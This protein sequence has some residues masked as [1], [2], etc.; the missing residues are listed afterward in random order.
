VQNT[1]AAI[2]LVVEGFRGRRFWYGYHKDSHTSVVGVRE[3]A[4][5]GCK[6]FLADRE[7]EAWIDQM[8]EDGDC[9]AG[10]GGVDEEEPLC[11]LFA[12]PGQSNMTGR[13]LPRDWYDLC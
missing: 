4:E 3:L 8:D 6:C 10:G 11:R 12:Y 1:T 13:R 7:V 9:G 2:K 5:A